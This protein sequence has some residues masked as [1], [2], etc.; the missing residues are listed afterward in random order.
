MSSTNLVDFSMRPNKAIERALVFQ[1]LAEIMRIENLSDQVYV[2]LGSVWFTDFLMAH[3]Q[4]GIETMVSI[5]NDEIVFRRAK[6]NKPYR[7]V[8]VVEG[9]SSERI[10]E[11]LDDK[12]L[13]ARP[14]I[15]WLDY[16]KPMDEERLVE[17]TDLV[18]SLPRRSVL[19]TTFNALPSRYGPPA[20]RGQRL[21]G[22]FGDCVPEDVV[23]D[24]LR[25]K[26][27]VQLMGILA[28]AVQT[29]LE[30]TALK[31]ARSGGFL[32]AFSLKYRDGAPMVTVGGYLP[33]GDATVLKTRVSELTWPGRSDE[34]II[35]QP[36][37]FK[38]IA[39][40]QERLPTDT[41]ITRELV[42]ELGFDLEEGHIKSF[43]DHYLL[44]PHYAQINR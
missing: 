16:D 28:K 7:T 8:R 9:D 14:W 6:F 21:A 41:P 13:S 35:T 4:L 11:L 17:L 38:E 3:R 36:L 23:S 30:S 43:V 34:P 22:L 10:S 25:L 42:Q 18:E 24:Q 27:E 33:D 44:Y 32:T 5:E 39:A 1:G 19:I 37:T 12:T 31:G 29:T 15:V 2:G 26:D 20:Q 40:L